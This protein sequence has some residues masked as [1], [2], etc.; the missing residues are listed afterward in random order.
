MKLSLGGTP[1]NSW[2]GG[3]RP[4]LQILTLFQTT[5][6]FR[7]GLQNPYPF[8][9]LEV[10]GHKTQQNKTEIMTSLLRLKPQQKDFLKYTFRIHILHFL[11]YSFRI[12]STNTLIRNRSSFVNHNR[13]QTKMGKINTPFQTRPAQKPYP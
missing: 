7:P 11:S 2:W 10:A 9:D 8:S 12:E 1:G 3:C 4:V 13:F 5:P 6:V